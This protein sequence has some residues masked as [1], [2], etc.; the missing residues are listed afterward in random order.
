MRPATTFADNGTAAA[1]GAT[2]A[3]K[4][5]L[6]LNTYAST[7]TSLNHCAVI[8]LLAAAECKWGTTKVIGNV[9]WADALIASGITINDGSGATTTFNVSPI[10]SIT[11]SGSGSPS[12]GTVEGC[13]LRC[14]EKAS[15]GTVTTIEAA[16]SFTNLRAL[17]VTLDIGNITAIA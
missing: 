9:Q 15:N 5:Q 16:V 10:K 12:N 8:A 1:N 4:Q 13:V 2:P 11:F 6:A 7:I 3:N 17:T 14:D